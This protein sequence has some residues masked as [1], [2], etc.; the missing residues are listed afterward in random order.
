MNNDNKALAALALFR[1]LYDK[2]TDIFEI[3]GEFIKSII[4]QKGL[5]EFNTTEINNY[6][7]NEYE[8]KVPETLISS[9][10]KR[11]CKKEN[12]IFSTKDKSLYTNSEYEKELE[13]IESQHKIINE[14]LI[15]FAEKH[16][17][18]GLNENEK[19]LLF[20]TLCQFIIEGSCDSEYTNIVNLF[21]IDCKKDIELQSLLDTITEGVVLYT[22]IRYNN[23][24]NERGSWKYPLNIYLEQEILFDAIGY[25]GELFQT[26]F[27]DFFN[28]VCDANKNHKCINLKYF[29]RTKQNVDIFFDTAESIVRGKSQLDISNNAMYQIVKGCSSPSDIVSK[30]TEFYSMLKKKKI[31]EDEKDDY[32]ENKN[33]KYNLESSEVLSAIKEELGDDIDEDK[34]TLLSYINILRKGKNNV[35]FEEV[36]YIM[37]TSKSTTK[38]MANSSVLKTN[39]DIPLVTDFYFITNKLW[40]KLNKGFGQNNYPRSF[41]LLT[42]AQIVLSSQIQSSVSKEFNQ[43]KEQLEKGE[44]KEEDVPTIIAGLKMKMDSTNK[45]DLDVEETF[46]YICCGNDIEKYIREKEISKQ[47][48]KEQVNEN[49]ELKKK[50]SIYDEIIDDDLSKL[51]KEQNEIKD[52]ISKINA[53]QILIDNKYNKKR[54]RLKV[55]LILTFPII[56]LTL[57][58]LFQVKEGCISLILSI[59]SIFLTC[60]P[61]YGKLLSIY[62]N[63]RKNKKLKSLKATNED[64][65]ILEEKLKGIESKINK[66]NNNRKQLVLT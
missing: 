4:R 8:F 11:F 47:K 50:L 45:M 53:T 44:L 64:K 18:K 60:N 36:K 13:S 25:N 48:I 3:L 57:F 29:K 10:L 54:K 66:I 5:L 27:N 2:Q 15:A 63:W 32:Y 51:E 42:R 65:N 22:G 19:L 17:N 43:L 37:L 52:H 6:L 33:H 41:S 61:K 39:G 9:S 21:V 55:I 62:T 1:K 26:L 38:Q 59:I 34:L 20:Q 56:T 40:F 58:A 14:R 12:G 30:K 24:I 49:E 23:D 28:L 31:E 16:L 35:P 7:K 46:N